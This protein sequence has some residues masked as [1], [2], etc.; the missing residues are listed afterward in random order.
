MFGGSNPTSWFSALDSM[1]RSGLSVIAKPFQNGILSGLEGLALGAIAGVKASPYATGILLGVGTLTLY[2]YHK[3]SL[4]LPQ[5]NFSLDAFL[6]HFYIKTGLG[7]NDVSHIQDLATRMDELEKGLKDHHAAQLRTLRDTLGTLKENEKEHHAD[8]T[9]RLDKVD[10][11]FSDTQRY[12]LS[13][14]ELV[15]T[16]L[17]T[18]TQL[19]TQNHAKV[20]G[21]LLILGQEGAATKEAVR[22]LGQV[23]TQ[24]AIRR[25]EGSKIEGRP[26]PQG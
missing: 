7:S 10:I 18:L 4:K 20:T 23:G 24:D 16:S 25:L 8:N 6:A 21:D 11:A 9:K 2:A 22:Q 13:Q 14:F 19:V 3:K 1:A 5:L 17:A 26:R 12:A 15:K